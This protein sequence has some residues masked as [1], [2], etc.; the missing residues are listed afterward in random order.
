MI[1]N[2][3]VSQNDQHAITSIGHR[4]EQLS[5]RLGQ[6]GRALYRRQD[7]MMD[8]TATH[9]NGCKLDL[10]NLLAAQDGDFAHDVFGIREWLNRD[11]GQLGCF[12]PRFRA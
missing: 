3:A 10:A 1:L 5:R 7:A 12:T 2:W 4:A 6:H 8:L 9:N 11:T